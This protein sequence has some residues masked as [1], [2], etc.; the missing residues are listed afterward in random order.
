[1][2]GSPM[3]NLAAM[4]PNINGS[5]SAGGPPVNTLNGGRML[6]LLND[7]GGF[8]NG[9]QG[10]VSGPILNGG[11]GGIGSSRQSAPGPLARL[12]SAIRDGFMDIVTKDQ[13]AAA[14]TGDGNA[15]P[16]AA[17]GTSGGSG[18]GADF[19]S[20]MGDVGLPSVVTGGIQAAVPDPGIP[21]AS[22]QE[23]F[24]DSRGFGLE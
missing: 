14:I 2:A 11:F 15:A 1:M 21:R 19:A 10:F 12:F 18:G 3:E 5:M 22:A 23:I 7:T 6:G 20:I 8:L 24:G 13:G 4:N 17:T 9:T 16:P